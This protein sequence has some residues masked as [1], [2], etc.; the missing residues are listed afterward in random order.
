MA[1]QVSERIRIDAPPTRCYEVAIDYERYPDWAKD[2]KQATVLERDAEGRGSKV[3]YRAA[4]FGRSARVARAAG[5]ESMSKQP[6]VYL[7]AFEAKY[8]FATGG[9]RSSRSARGS[10]R[11]RV[12]SGRG[13]RTPAITHISK[14]PGSIRG[15]GPFSPAQDR[16]D[17]LRIL[18]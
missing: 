17:P 18:T 3:E 11:Y 10:P 8:D 7:G 16:S 4:A 9:W 6:A 12:R 5:I 13:F 2:V 1:E 14:I 15:C